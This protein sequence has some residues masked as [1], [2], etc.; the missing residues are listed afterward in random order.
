MAKISF[1]ARLDEI[2][3]QKLKFIS[4]KELRSLNAQLE[5]FI[6]QGIKEYENNHGSINVQQS[7][8]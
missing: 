1:Q 3:H 7:E 2:T 8:E 5:Y 4:D 6:L